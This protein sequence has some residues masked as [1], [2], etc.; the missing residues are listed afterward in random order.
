M[1]RCCYCLL[2]KWCKG[3]IFANFVAKF[4][5]I[6]QSKYLTYFANKYNIYLVKYAKNFL[7]RAGGQ[8]AKF[9]SVLA[10]GGQSNNAQAASNDTKLLMFVC[11]IHFAN[12]TTHSR[13]K[14]Q[15]KKS[16]WQWIKEYFAVFVASL[17]IAISMYTFVN[18]TKLVAGGITGIASVLAFVLSALVDGITVEQTMPVLYVLLNVPIMILSL[19]YLRGDFTFKTIFSVLVSYAA[20]A[21]L[22][23]WFPAFQ[24]AESRIISTI[25]GGVLLGAGMYVA[26]VN[27]ASNGGTEIIGK[28]I[29]LKRPELDLSKIILIINFI[30]TVVGGVVIMIVEG[31][32]FWIVMYSL[33]F[34]VIA[35]EFMGILQRGFD[36]PQKF[37]I[38]TSKHQQLKDAIIANFKRGLSVTETGK[39]YDGIERK[40]IVVVVQ[41]RQSPRLK[42][43]IAT[44]DPDAFTI[45]KDVHDVFSRPTFNWSYKTN[46]NTNQK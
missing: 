26:S 8:V 43:L 14:L 33:L 20:M 13:C 6:L 27:N 46:E 18:P 23:K 45:V 42:Q 4:P 31:E 36:H 40:M 12:L 15:N 35:G 37:L 10:L 30:L 17:F 5:T 38:V 2:C 32:S 21:V 3:H 41:F 7:H 44:I 19:V 11:T 9:T 29:N 24:F 16:L 28:V 1:L 25:I 34:V 22:P 39:P